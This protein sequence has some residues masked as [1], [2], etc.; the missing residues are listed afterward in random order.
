M[1]VSWKVKRRENQKQKKMDMFAGTQTES[2]IE[3]ETERVIFSYYLKTIEVLILYSPFCKICY[4]I[5][6]LNYCEKH[7]VAIIQHCFIYSCMFKS[8]KRLAPV[9]SLF[10]E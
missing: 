1:A 7:N 6:A 4:T 9:I 2:S 3:T 10:G 8:D 5:C